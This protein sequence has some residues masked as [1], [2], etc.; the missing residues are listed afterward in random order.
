M[1]DDEFLRAEPRSHHEE[2]PQGGLKLL[3]AEPKCRYPDFWTI[4]EASR[5]KLERHE[6][7]FAENQCLRARRFAQKSGAFGMGKNIP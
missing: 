7:G 2:T 1:S 5:E 4:P 6:M 3:Q